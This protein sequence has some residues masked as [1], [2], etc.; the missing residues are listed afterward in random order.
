MRP[1]RYFGWAKYAQSSLHRCMTGK[2]APNRCEDA[3]SLTRLMF[4]VQGCKEIARKG[5]A[6]PVN[7]CEV[8]DDKGCL[9]GTGTC[10]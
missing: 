1:T 6:L 8:T 5:T 10:R 4:V 2:L 3:C 9:A 7:L